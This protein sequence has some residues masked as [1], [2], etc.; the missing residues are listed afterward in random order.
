MRSFV[1]MRPG[2]RAL[3]SSASQTSCGAWVP[4]PWKLSAESRQMIPLGAAEPTRASVSNSLGRRRQAVEA[5]SNLLDRARGNEA[6]KFRER[7]VQRLEVPGPEKRSDPGR[8]EPG[9]GKSR[10]SHL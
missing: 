4:I 9:R 2:L 6:L 5:G 3:R 7:D 8:F 10:R 1:G